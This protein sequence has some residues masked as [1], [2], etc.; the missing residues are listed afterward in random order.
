[1]TALDSIVVVIR[2]DANRVALDPARTF[3]AIISFRNCT[4]HS[5]W[6]RFTI[7]TQQLHRKGFLPSA[8][9]VVANQKFP[10]DECPAHP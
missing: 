5:C 2:Q 9:A 7:G 1:M 3:G 6:D 10:G 8:A 4:P